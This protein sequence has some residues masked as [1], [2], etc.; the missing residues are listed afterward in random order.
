M[1]KRLSKRHAAIKKTGKTSLLPPL[2]SRYNI[3]VVVGLVLLVIAI[4]NGNTFAGSPRV[5]GL[6]IADRGS[7]GGG[8]NAREKR[9]IQGNLK[10]ESSR[11]DSPD[12]SS[13][14]LPERPK[15]NSEQSP[16]PPG[17][18]KPGA[19][20]TT[21]ILKQERQTLP[22]PTVSPVISPKIQM[23]QEETPEASRPPRL[24]RD[25]LEQVKE[26]FKKE[27][28]Q[29]TNKHTIKPE[30]TEPTEEKKPIP[31]QAI[32]KLNE[33]ILP[34]Q[35]VQ[36]LLKTKVFTTVESKKTSTPGESNATT[37]KTTLTELNNE[38]VFKVK[39]TAKKN[40]FG[41]IP[42]N[43]AKTAFVSA[44]TGEVTKIDESFGQKLLEFLSL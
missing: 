22:Q 23:E 11:N 20:A 32:K 26:T 40:L 28:K 36:N 34:D 37:Q 19:A 1:K 2:S 9:T 14:K 18:E 7:A 30:Q 6:S 21:T 8:L 4:A 27:L 13:D 16:L 35:A 31:A 25:Q 41:F 44:E 43:I 5:L 10:Q 24:D 15:R 38:P 29:E 39:G 12:K 3:I 33:T 42:V 17:K